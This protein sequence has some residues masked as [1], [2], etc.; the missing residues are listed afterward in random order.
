MDLAGIAVEVA[1][2]ARRPDRDVRSETGGAVVV[3]GD[4]D[5]LTRLAC[6]RLIVARMNRSTSPADL[7]DVLRV[8]LLLQVSLFVVAAIEAAAFVG[9]FGPGGLGS[10][11]LSLAAATFVLVTR[12]RLDRLGRRGRR[13]LVALEVVL[14]GSL[15]LD[16]ILALAMAG[17]VP[18]LMPAITQGL[19]PI[20]IVRLVRRAAAIPG[21]TPPADTVP[22]EPF[23]TLEPAATHPVV[24]AGGVA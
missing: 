19:L 21:G 13:A 16:T 22:S 1:R 7:L 6:R 20:A 8:L 12:R 11:V 10:V 24:I 3:D 23:T 5:A 15:A 18:G 9:F 2:R 4:L 17:Q 14:V